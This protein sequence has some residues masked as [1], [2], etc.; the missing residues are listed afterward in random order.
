MDVPGISTREHAA[1]KP[2]SRRLLSFHIALGA[3][4][5]ALVFVYCERS[6]ADPD[7]WWH[8]RNA[9]YLLSTHHLPRVDMYSFTLAG[10][11]WID[12]EWLSEIPYYLAYRAFGM[13]GVFALELV[14]VESIVFA[15]LFFSYRYGGS[16][17]A[18]WVATCLGVMLAAVNIGPRTILFGWMSLLVLLAIL[19]RYQSTGKGPLWAIPLLFCVWVNTHGSWLV[20]LIVFVV[21]I[22]AGAFQGSYGKLEVIPWPREKLRKLIV[23]LA[24]SI[25]ALFLN[26]YTYRLVFYPF[27]L[28]FRQKLNIARVEEWASVDFHEPRG[29]LVLVFLFALLISA[30]AARVRWTLPELIL[31]LFAL[32]TSLTYVRFLFLAAILVVP[33]LA[34]RLSFLP[35]YPREIDTP[36]VNACVVAVLVGIMA[37]QLPS[38]TALEKEIA[39]QY[40]LRSIA[41]LRTHSQ[42]ARVFNHFGWGGYLIWNAPEIPTFIDGR[43]DIF[44]H[45]GVLKD[46]LDVTDMKNSLDILDRYQVR[47]V[48]FTPKEALA[49]LLEHTERWKVA[50]RDDVSI[51]FER[52]PDH[53]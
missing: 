27:D 31:T 16:I 47:Y 45:K 35:P 18:S 17:M 50:Y 29:K 53:R 48:L 20:G 38:A 6:V 14:V 3:A 1:E 2:V 34:R 12:H 37:W 7:L 9:Q 15:I 26:P 43:T 51:V 39:R 46:Y 36:I 4:L 32:Y 24:A 22:A 8:L 23:T 25:A 5:F 19:W 13:R 41:Y 44:D 10:S 40:P 42:G 49:Y 52:T 11:P 33:I 21:I 28:A 30:V